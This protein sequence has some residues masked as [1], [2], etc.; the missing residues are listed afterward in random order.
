[1]TNHRLDIPLGCA[2]NVAIVADLSK[3][4]AF[5]K[6]CTE[7]PL[8]FNIKPPARGDMWPFFNASWTG[9]MLYSLLATP[10]EIYMLPKTDKF[11]TELVNHNLMSGF[12]VKKE[13]FT[14]AEDPQ[15]HLVSMRDSV[16]NVDYEITDTGVE[17]FNGVHWQVSIPQDE[18]MLFCGLLTDAIL[19]FYNEMKYGNRGR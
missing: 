1:M 14:F 12:K 16:Q 9:Y 15:Y 11:Y 17:F 18:L 2:V 4:Q 8:R 13:Q 3:T 10:K 7:V 6:A 19:G 5:K